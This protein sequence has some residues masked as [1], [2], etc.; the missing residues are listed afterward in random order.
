MEQQLKQDQNIANEMT[1]ALEEN[2]FVPY[3]QPKYDLRTNK[4]AGAES[5]IR[6]QHPEKGLIPPALFIPVFERNGF[7]SKV[8]YYMW[9]NV[10]KTLRKWI[11]EK[12][13]ILP[14][15]INV[16]RIDMYNPLLVD[17]FCNLIDKYNASSTKQRI[18]SNDGRFRFWLFILECFERYAC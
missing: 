3:F 4:I 12:R 1:K 6:W 16:S 5:L 11:D 10:C 18:C 14:I 17:I 9:E 15:S 2:Q 8:D 7:V 13:T